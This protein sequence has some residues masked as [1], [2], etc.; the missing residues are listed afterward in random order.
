MRPLGVGVIHLLAFAMLLS[1]CARSESAADSTDRETV[2][3]IDVTGIPYADARADLRDAGLD[4]R[5]S[6]ETSS[7]DRDIVIEQSLEP[8]AEV[9][10]GASI[11]LTVSTGEASQTPRAS[12]EPPLTWAQTFEQVNDGVVRI[13]STF[14]DGAATGSGFLIA[15]DLVATNA[16]VVAGS[17]DMAIDSGSDVRSGRIIGLDEAQD[18]ALVETDEPF[19]GHVFEGVGELPAVGNDVAAFGYPLGEPLSIAAGTVSGLDRQI[20]DMSGAIQ[21]DAAVNPGNSGG[22]L[23]EV[24]GDVVG[25]IVAKALQAEGL[26]YAIPSTVAFPQLT[27]WQEDPVAIASPPCDA[28]DGGDD[29]WTVRADV[30]HPEIDAVIDTFQSYVTGINTGDYALAYDQWSQRL[31]ERTSYD[32]FVIEQTSSFIYGFVITGVD[33]PNDHELAVDAG[34]WSEQDPA[35]GPQGQDCSVWSLTY[36]M[37]RVD[38]RWLIDG[39]EPNMADSPFACEAE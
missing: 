20:G 8:G 29:S 25:V 35:Y 19:D 10:A 22:P 7:A 3:I 4:V 24:D 16:H 15:S 12:Q 17:L 23:L 18:L 39:A 32:D 1:A 13:K 36:R 38:G 5:R 30:D 28:A 37:V 14:C 21:T 31:Q 11:T 27:Q 33:Q 2:S 34:F 9:E 26:A 6:E